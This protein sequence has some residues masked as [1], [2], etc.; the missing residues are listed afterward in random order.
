MALEYVPASHG[1]HSVLN[2]AVEYWPVGHDIQL[3]LLFTLE[4]VPTG[5]LVHVRDDVAPIEVE[6]VPAKQLEHVDFPVSVEYAPAGH[7]LQTH[8]IKYDP[9]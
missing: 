6:Y 2:V 5:Q 3:T 7:C 1:L 4:K 9:A 8:S